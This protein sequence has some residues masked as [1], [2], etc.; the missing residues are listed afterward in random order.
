M[1]VITAIILA[2]C[3]ISNLWNFYGATKLLQHDKSLGMGLW[4]AFVGF[5]S[6]L[7]SFGA[8]WWAHP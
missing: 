7:C 2:V 8:G 1:I 3:G 4:V 6:A 5:C